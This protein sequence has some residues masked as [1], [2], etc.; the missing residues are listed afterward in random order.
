M[1]SLLKFG[2]AR[3]VATPSVDGVGIVMGAWRAA[4]RPVATGTREMTRAA[5]RASVDGF[6]ITTGVRG[7]REAS[8]SSG[9][10]RLSLASLCT[11]ICALAAGAV[12]AVA[13][14]QFGSW[15]TEAGQ[16]RGPSG[17]AV[18]GEGDV[19]VADVNNKR[20]DKFD[21]SGGFLFALGLGVENGALEDQTCTA[22]TV[23]LSGQGGSLT[24]LDL[25]VIPESRRLQ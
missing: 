1:R 2:R 24:G 8:R 22:E 21:G 15:G 17:V 23:C 9:V 18:N 11:L 10:R 12:P 19:Y 4:I 6:G 20:V 5:L 13:A 3:R 16:F 7:V 14:T 25:A